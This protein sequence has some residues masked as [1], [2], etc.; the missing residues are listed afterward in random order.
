M[1]WNEDQ[2][3]TERIGRIAAGAAFLLLSLSDAT[4]QPV[5]VVE[6]RT[7]ADGPNA[8][9]VIRFDSP[10]DHQLSRLLIK[11][12]DRTVETLRP[13][14]EAEPNILAASGPLLQAGDYQLHWSAVS[15]LRGNVT[16]GSIPFTARR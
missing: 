5:H 11:Q 13:I 15:L 14:L 4:A 12:G 6:F 1:V 2:G 16:E 3:V 10:V 9:Y 7:L 8:Q